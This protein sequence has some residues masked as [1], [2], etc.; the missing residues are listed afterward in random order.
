[1]YHHECIALYMYLLNCLLFVWYML[2]DRMSP[3]VSV[4]M[5]TTSYGQACRQWHRSVAVSTERDG[6][7]T[8]SRL[9][10]MFVRQDIRNAVDITC[11]SQSV[12]NSN[13]LSSVLHLGTKSVCSSVGWANSIT[14]Q[15]QSVSVTM[16]VCVSVSNWLLSSSKT[17]KL[18]SRNFAA[19]VCRVGADHP[20]TPRLRGASSPSPNQEGPHGV[21]GLIT[22]R[23]GPIWQWKALYVD[24]KECLHRQV[25]LGKDWLIDWVRLNVP[26]NTL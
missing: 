4:K 26:S 6:S 8:S 1:M 24:I 23:K 20:R 5:A 15:S 9:H 19:V 7:V 10:Q 22:G 13:F 16:S 25:T 18:L 11:Q 17:S 3:T 21:K 2:I 12:S 14:G